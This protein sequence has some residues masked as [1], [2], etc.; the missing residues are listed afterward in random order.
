MPESTPGKPFTRRKL[1]VG[2]AG[3]LAGL[4]GLGF[5][6]RQHENS[7]PQAITPE[8]INRKVMA[9]SW[10]D[11]EK[12][13]GR[14]SFTK[15]VAEAYVTFTKT[16]RVNAEQ[17][18]KVTKFTETDDAFIQAVHQVNPAFTPTQNQW[19]YTHY[20][21]GQVFINNNKL[22]TQA[23][24]QGGTAGQAYLDALWHEWGHLD[25]TPRT[26]GRF[27]NNPQITYTSPS[28]GKNE[29]WIRYRGAAVYTDTYYG[30]LHFE[31]VLNESITVRRMIEQIG[32]PSVISARDYYNN[33]VDF[34]PRLTKS[35]GITLDQ[36]YDFHATSDI[37]GFLTRIGEK[38]PGTGDAL[39]KGMNL[40]IGI[41]RE[42]KQQIESTGAYTLLK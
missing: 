13:N 5:L 12:P 27:L 26:T 4:V 25:I 32:L 16:P 18:L 38:L 23:S 36:L 34:F 31:E 28:S 7:E 9:F 19:G 39:A 8:F 1:L 22:K 37:E 30:L 14:E 40:A 21:S 20:E 33:G 17:L 35:I 3:A 41:H 11:A 2:G 29:Q 42:N 10:Q 24:Q 15:D 6:R